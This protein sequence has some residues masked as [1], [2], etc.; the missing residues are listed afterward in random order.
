MPSETSEMIPLMS[1][2]DQWEFPRDRLRLSTVLGA[3]A[4][5]MVMRGDAQ[6]IRG[7][8]GRVKCAVKMVKGEWRGE[9]FLGLLK[10]SQTDGPLSSQYTVSIPSGVELGR[11][12]GA[13]LP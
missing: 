9:W 8:I 13:P 6:G 4:F 5:G 10:T 3:G 1:R 11:L 12:R 7:S 2:A